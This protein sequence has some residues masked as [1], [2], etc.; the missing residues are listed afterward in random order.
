MPLG[1]VALQPVTAEAHRNFIIFCLRSEIENSI[2]SQH[3]VQRC[4]YDNSTFSHYTHF[5]S[6]Y[7]SAENQAFIGVWGV[8]KI[9]ILALEINIIQENSGYHK[10]CE[11]GQTC[12]NIKQFQRR[13]ACF[14]ILYGCLYICVLFDN[15]W[16]IV[17]L[18]NLISKQENDYQ[19]TKQ[20][21]KGTEN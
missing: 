13:M 11:V 21:F 16:Y 15:V 2:D 3:S 5:F 1:F 4:V 14:R 18:E 8:F 20:C 9:Q 19:W 6:I 10:I 17:R 12:L 7:G